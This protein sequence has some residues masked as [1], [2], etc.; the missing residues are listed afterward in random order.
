[1]L[2]FWGDV[3]PLVPWTVSHKI[4]AYNNPRKFRMQNGNTPTVVFLA[5]ASQILD[6]KSEVRRYSSAICIILKEGWHFTVGGTSFNKKCS[7]M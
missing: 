2:S 3:K 7:E 6:F 4:C 5:L 1:M